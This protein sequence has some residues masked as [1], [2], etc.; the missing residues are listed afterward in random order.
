MPPGASGMVQSWGECHPADDI[1]HI[2]FCTAR[3]LSWEQRS[4]DSHRPLHMRQAQLLY[5]G[6]ERSRIALLA[7]ACWEVPFV[8]RLGR[9]TAGT[10]LL[11]KDAVA[12]LRAMTRRP[13]GGGS[14]PK[15]AL[16]GE[17]DPSAALACTK[18]PTKR[19]NKIAFTARHACLT[20]WRCMNLS[21]ATSQ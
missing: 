10:V 15:S 14:G 9:C 4:H 2:I 6:L 12:Y 7:Q 20:F 18:R 8:V 16:L 11:S 17:I 5:S 1:V 21:Y 3:H 19:I 13:A